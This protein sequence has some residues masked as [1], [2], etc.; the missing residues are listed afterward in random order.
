[1]K[2][3]AAFQLRSLGT[4]PRGASRTITA[5]A[6][7]ITAAEGFGKA[8]SSVRFTYKKNQ[9]IILSLEDLMDFTSMLFDKIK[10]L[11]EGV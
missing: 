10:H 4:R 6:T 2:A 5:A 11:V 9:N 7:L 3:R 1:M 8:F